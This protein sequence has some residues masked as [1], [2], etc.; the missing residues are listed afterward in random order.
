MTEPTLPVRPTLRQR[1]VA[2][3]TVGTI[4]RRRVVNALMGG[5]VAIAAIITTLPL[6]LILFHLVRSGA[7]V[8][9][10]RSG[11][12]PEENDVDLI[13]NPRSRCAPVALLFGCAG[14]KTLQ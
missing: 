14:P 4:M 8:I 7:S 10:R 3:R 1:A 9:L 2:E 11:A 12:E 5:V 13:R 6:L